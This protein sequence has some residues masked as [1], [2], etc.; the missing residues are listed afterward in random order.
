MPED[1]SESSQSQDK[2]EE[3][4]PAA[5]EPAPS[6][7][8]GE[9]AEEP[10]GKTAAPAS[11]TSS[12]ASP[13]AA[14]ASPS[15][16]DDIAK[17]RSP[18]ES[19][20]AAFDYVQKSS[21]TDAIQLRTSDRV[22]IIALLLCCILE[23]LSLSYTPFAGMRLPVV[24]ICDV[25][26][27]VSTVLFLVYRLGILC[28]LTPRQAIVCWQLMMGCVFFGIF[29]CINVGVGIAFAVTNMTSEE[30]ASQP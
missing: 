5:N 21:R 22:T 23:V 3:A 27:G 16:A 26:L 29:L 13:T 7:S 2:P 25:V 24:L 6:Q 9:K 18:W 11:P 10:A 8:S 15:P 12:T 19:S 20:A 4:A 17:R 30:A 28:S 14:A 1:K